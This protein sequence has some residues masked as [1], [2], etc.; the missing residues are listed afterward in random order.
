MPTSHTKYKQ[1]D[2]EGIDILKDDLYEDSHEG[3]AAWLQAQFEIKQ[4]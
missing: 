3:D 4:M 1:M 2:F